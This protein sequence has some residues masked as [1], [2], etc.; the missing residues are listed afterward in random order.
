VT[1][2]PVPDG[3]STSGVDGLVYADGRL[4]AIQNGIEPSRVSVFDLAPDGA[5]IARARIL[6][7]NHPILDE[8]TLGT[9]VDGVLYFSANNQ[10]HRYHDV[11]NPPRPEDLRDAVIL[12]V[13]V[14]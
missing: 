7:M 5:G 13:P 9:V 2:L 4:V 1:R 10:G 14:R 8:P 11:K 3:D 6:V 12:R